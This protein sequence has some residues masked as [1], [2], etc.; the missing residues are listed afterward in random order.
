MRASRILTTDIRF[1]S[2]TQ[3]A[4]HVVRA[5]PEQRAAVSSATPGVKPLVLARWQHPSVPADVSLY[6]NVN[7]T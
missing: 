4:Q 5:S 7:E 6:L 2:S 1:Q 3:P